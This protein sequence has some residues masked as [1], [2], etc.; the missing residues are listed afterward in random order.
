MRTLLLF[1]VQGEI[2]MKIFGTCPR[3]I[4]RQQRDPA[5]NLVTEETSGLNYVMAAAESAGHEIIVDSIADSIEDLVEKI[6]KNNPDVIALSLDTCLV[7]VGKE[8]INKANA[9]KKRISIVGGS[10]FL[11]GKVESPFDYAVVGEG[12]KTFVEVLDALDKNKDCSGIKGIS[13]SNRGQIV[14]TPRRKRISDLDSLPS[15]Y[16]GTELTKNKAEGTL[17]YPPFDKQ[18]G[19]VSF[20]ASR[21]CN[22]SCSYCTNPTEWGSKVIHRSIENVVD[23]I[24]K[25]QERF[26]TNIACFNDLNFTFNQKWVVDFCNLVKE[27]G[28]QLNWYAM[29]NIST[30]RNSEMLKLMKEAGCEKLLFGIESLADKERKFGTYKNIKDVLE[31]TQEAGIMTH[32][33]FMVGL[34]DDSYE[35]V[36]ETIPAICSLPL[37][38]IRVSVYTPFP[39]TRNYGKFEIT[40]PDLEKHDGA[41]LVF[42]HPNLSNEQCQQ[43]REEI[44]Q[45]FYSSSEYKAR[46]RNF[47]RKNPMFK[48]SFE[49]FLGGKNV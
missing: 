46:V 25:V 37:H 40:E 30:A 49:I 11:S 18:K 24:K 38:S 9:I 16:R 44:N 2:K 7:N 43:L 19:Y 21:G 10:H 22:N 17:S 28:I 20:T 32:G 23:E 3:K 39:G 29:S 5:G 31:L 36:R 15:P 14:T 26:G 47:L 27:K 34:P 13:F 12:E 8:I 41:T 45:T 48:E 4:I 33:F 42:N 35:S 6:E 1:F